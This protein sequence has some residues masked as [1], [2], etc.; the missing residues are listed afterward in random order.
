MSGTETDPQRKAELET[1]SR[2]C[3]V[4]AEG[5]PEDFYQALQ[6]TWFIQ[7]ALQIESNGHSVSLG[8]VDQ[9]LYPFYEEDIRAGRLTEDFAREL[10]ES[11]WLKVFS[12]NKIRGWSHTRFSAGSPL[13]QN[14]TI[15][16]T[17]TRGGRRCQPAQLPHPRLGGQS[18]AAAAQ[19]VRALSQRI[20]PGVH[21]RLHPRH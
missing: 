7:L 12:I 13:Y 18:A 9:Y 10:L 17:D 15:W 2:N 1:I 11:A 19:P 8:R 6:L 16:R 4:I 14:V 3:A 21:G 20:E 5:A